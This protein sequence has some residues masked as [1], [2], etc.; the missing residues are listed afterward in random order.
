MLKF[1]SSL[2][3]PIEYLE[4]SQSFYIVTAILQCFIEASL[5]SYLPFIFTF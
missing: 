5:L 3:K 1:L 4:N 2:I